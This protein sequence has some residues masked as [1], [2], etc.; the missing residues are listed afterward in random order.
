MKITNEISPKTH[1]IDHIDD[2]DAHAD[3]D[4]DEDK[5]FVLRVYT[6]L[7]QTTSEFFFRFFS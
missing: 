3:D 7:K 1:D 4:D 6:I 5:S 2:D